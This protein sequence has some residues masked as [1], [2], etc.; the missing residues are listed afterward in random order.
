MPHVHN[1]GH[2]ANKKFG[3]PSF[4]NPILVACRFDSSY[5]NA[6]G[7]QPNQNRL[8]MCSRT[9]GVSTC[10]ADV[11][12]VGCTCEHACSRVPG[13]PKSKTCPQ[14]TQAQCRHCYVQVTWHHY[15][16]PC[17][18]TLFAAL[19]PTYLSAYLVG[20]ATNTCRS[21]FSP[22]SALYI[23]PGHLHSFST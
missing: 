7:E 4:E 6:P 19:S 15:C 21:A 3:V 8:E 1:A 13:A 2:E 18:S 17:L 23:R 9:L 14:R 20:H 10:H 16:Y 12:Q 11:E 5:R 22:P